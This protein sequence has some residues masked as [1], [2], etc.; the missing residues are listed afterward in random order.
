MKSLKYTI[1]KRIISLI[2]FVC[3]IAGFVQAQTIS[4]IDEG[5]NKDLNLTAKDSLVLDYLD[6]FHSQLREPR[7]QLYK[8][9]NM[10]TFLKLDTMTGKIWQ[11]QFSTKGGDYRFETPLD[12]YSR[13]S[14]YFDEPICGRFTLY[15]TDNMYN[16]ILLDQIDGRCWQV[17]WNIE[18]ENRGV[19][20]IY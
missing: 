19:M 13:I 11:V 1:M 10:W 2:A 3:C 9:Q 16:F 15:A 5:L 4:F 8:T 18:P 6:A 7:Y 14:E 17:Q 12:T 20:R